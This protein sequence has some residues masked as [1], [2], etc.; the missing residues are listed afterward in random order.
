MQA[1]MALQ[2]QDFD[3]VLMDIQM[4]VMDGLAATRQIRVLP[5]PLCDVP[6]IAVTANAMNGDRE[7]Y[8]AEGMNEY[9]AKP[10]DQTT[11]LSV[12]ARVT[13]SLGQASA[14]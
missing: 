9:V 2:E 12:V 8:L 5:Y 14:A 6:I 1:L 7:K 11:L 13:A 4:P 10:I 3:L